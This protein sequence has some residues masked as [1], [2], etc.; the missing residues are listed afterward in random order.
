MF[1]Y[2]WLKVLGITNILGPH[3]QALL[4]VSCELVVKLERLLD[5]FKVLGVGED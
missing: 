1:K 3:A 4:H 5:Q 2:G